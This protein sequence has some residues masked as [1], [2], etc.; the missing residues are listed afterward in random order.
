MSRNACRLYQP[1][2]EILSHP[3]FRLKGNPFLTNTIKNF[4]LPTLLTDLEIRFG[5]IQVDHACKFI[6]NFKEE[7]LEI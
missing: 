7:Q 4:R 5:K 6:S 1:I 3:F 2:D